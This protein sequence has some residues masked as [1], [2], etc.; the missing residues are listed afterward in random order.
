MPGAGGQTT[1]MAGQIKRIIESIIAQRA[2]GDPLLALTT[3]TKLVLRGF[4][5]TRFDA[6]SPDDPE[7]LARLRAVASEMRAH[8]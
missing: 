4:D 5:P 6:W 8:V 3:E 2:Q 1:H 7:I